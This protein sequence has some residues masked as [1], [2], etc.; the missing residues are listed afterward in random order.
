MGKILIEEAPSG[1]L[2]RGKL[3]FVDEDAMSKEQYDFICMAQKDMLL[4]T[5]MTPEE[6]WDFGFRCWQ[7]GYAKVE[8]KTNADRI[9]SM[10]D[11]ELES[12]LYGYRSFPCQCCN[13]HQMSCRQAL[14]E[15]LKS[16]AEK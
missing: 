9:R 5:N 15:W 11:E 13:K 14:R 10:S 1:P 12:F 6:A 8:R 3:Y 4:H 7:M 2:D 16:P